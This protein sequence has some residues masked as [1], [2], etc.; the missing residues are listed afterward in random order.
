MIIHSFQVIF[1]AFDILLNFAH[2]VVIVDPVHC[3]LHVP[4]PVEFRSQFERELLKLFL[5]E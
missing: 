5:L 4:V 3:V 1:N 2:Q